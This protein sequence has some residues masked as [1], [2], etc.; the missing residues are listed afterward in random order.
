[1]VVVIV[2]VILPLVEFMLDGIH[3]VIQLRF[4]PG[5]KMSATP[6][7]VM[8]VGADFAKLIVQM[9]RLG[10]R[11]MPAFHFVINARI[12]LRNAHVQIVVRTVFLGKADTC[13]TCQTHSGKKTQQKTRD[14]FHIAYSFKAFQP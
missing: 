9:L 7:H 13:D 3:A 14:F 1:V 4:I 5:Q 2:I 10:R 6:F 11:H 12:E 8:F